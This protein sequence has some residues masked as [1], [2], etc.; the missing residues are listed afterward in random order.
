[1]K[2][3]SPIFFILAVST[4]SIFFPSHTLTAQNA[5]PISELSKNSKF[6][7][8][9][10]ERMSSSEATKILNDKEVQ[11]KFP[12]SPTARLTEYMCGTTHDEEVIYGLG[13]DGK[14][15]YFAVGTDVSSTGIK[16]WQSEDMLTWKSIGTVFSRENPPKFSQ[17]PA[18]PF[19]YEFKPYKITENGEYTF[20]NAA[21]ER[22]LGSPSE[23]RPFWAPCVYYNVKDKTY[24]LYYCCSAFG[25]RNSFIG[26]A[27][28]KT[29]DKGWNDCGILIH[30]RRDDGKRFNAIDPAVI[31]DADGNPWMIYGSY[32]GG[33][34]LIQLNPK[35]PSKLLKPGT[36]GKAI[37]SRRYVDFLPQE[38]RENALRKIRNYESAG[39]GTEG[40]SLVY[41][42]E[43]G[44]YYLFVA[45]D[46]LNWA[47][48]TR[49][50][51]SKNIEGPYLDF[52]G[53]PMLYDQ[54]EVGHEN[55]YGTKI[56]G[57][58][59]WTLP[60]AG[61]AATGHTAL[62][63]DKNNHLMFGSNSKWNQVPGSFMGL[64]E[65]L[66]TNDGWPLLSP[67]LYAGGN[68]DEIAKVS[69]PS[70]TAERPSADW[71][72]VVFS[73]SHNDGRRT[74]QAKSYILNR[75]GKISKKETDCSW[76]LWWTKQGTV[77]V[78][79]LPDGTAAKGRVAYAWDAYRK[80]QTVVFSGITEKGVPVWGERITPPAFP[81]S[82][83]N[84]AN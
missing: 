56:V 77:M 80:R 57:A 36:H 71:E 72:F 3:L 37:C 17:N 16:I 58:Y 31:A 23:F 29:V 70:I 78:V 51:R 41:D 66:W 39:Y 79:I 24:Y 75:E 50:G 40:A 44:Y 20:P 19:F 73:V 63:R 54:D 12:V 52:N 65:V 60:N 84:T 81:L 27:K 42:K 48:H 2:S 26:C 55:V 33:I 30:T 83:Q 13:S 47:Y 35:D 61:W 15:H 9:N 1:M 34:A 7:N 32:F 64:R 62:F 53:K 74:D 76:Q 25:S 69:I 45:Y 5:D 8:P 82:T 67:Q 59:Q 21:N 18:R 68:Q 22:S 38:K 11:I 49:V 14:M 4:C 6:F 10:G 28:S 46:N 43:R